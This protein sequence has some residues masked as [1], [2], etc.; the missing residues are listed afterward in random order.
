M[1]ENCPIGIPLPMAF[2]R[3]IRG[4][5]QHTLPCAELSYALQDI[6]ICELTLV[7]LVP[8]TAAPTFPEAQEGSVPPTESTAERLRAQTTKAE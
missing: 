7:I 1:V 8:K 5:R 2:S 4:M 3:D 6:Y